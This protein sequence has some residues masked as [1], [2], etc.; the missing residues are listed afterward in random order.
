MAPYNTFAEIDYFIESLIEIIQKNEEPKL[1]EKVIINQNNQNN[2]VTTFEIIDKFSNVKSWDSRHREIMILGK[3][4][5]RLDNSFRND[6]NIINGCESLTWLMVAEKKEDIYRFQADSDAKIIRGLLVIIL[7]AFNDTTRL[8][9]ETF[10]IESYFS[11]LGL[12]QHLSPSRGNGVLAIV[13][14]IKALVQ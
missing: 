13:S 7:A 10:D 8:Q 6:E 12:M 1:L 11:K 14:K 3:Q 2:A 5:Y 4:L 9:I